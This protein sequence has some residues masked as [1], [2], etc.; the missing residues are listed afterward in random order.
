LL[1]NAG[2]DTALVPDSLRTAALSRVFGFE[3]MPAPF[4]ISHLQIASLLE[5]AGA[6]PLTP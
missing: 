4:V 5:S 2:D 3:I 1:E 6:P